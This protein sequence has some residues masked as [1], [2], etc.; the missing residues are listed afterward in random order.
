MPGGWI[1][2]QQ[3]ITIVA[4]PFTLIYNRFLCNCDHWRNGRRGLATS[5]H[6]NENYLGSSCDAPLHAQASPYRNR[7]PAR[8]LRVFPASSTDHASHRSSDPAFRLHS[9]A[10]EDRSSGG[11]RRV[12]SRTAAGAIFFDRTASSARTSDPRWR[13]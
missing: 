4:L 10:V 2:Y 1:G 12:L 7:T 6:R 8:Q 13:V 3:L 9:S 11:W 5:R